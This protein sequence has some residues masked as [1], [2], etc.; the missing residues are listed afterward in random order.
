MSWIYLALAAFIAGILSLSHLR[1]TSFLFCAFVWEIIRVLVISSWSRS[2][3]AGE[4]INR[5]NGGE[6]MV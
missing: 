5:A 4:V 6:Q 3:Q 1:S 2:P